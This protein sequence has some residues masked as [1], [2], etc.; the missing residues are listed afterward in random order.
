V[1]LTTEK[2]SFVFWKIF[3]FNENEEREGGNLIYIL[4]L[5]LLLVL[6][7]PKCSKKLASFHEI[8]SNL[9]SSFCR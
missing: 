9:K 8:T 1:F 2:E 3:I 4:E 5:E 7:F 6:V